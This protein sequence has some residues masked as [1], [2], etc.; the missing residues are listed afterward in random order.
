MD[1]PRNACLL[2]TSWNLYS[3]LG[4]QVDFV[5]LC[6]QVKEGKVIGQIR[7]GIDF[8]HKRLNNKYILEARQ[9]CEMMAATA[10]YSNE[11]KVLLGRLLIAENKDIEALDILKEVEEDGC[12]KP[13]VIEKI[14]H[15]RSGHL[16]PRPQRREL[17]AGRD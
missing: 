8:A 9:I 4:E 10:Q 13:F 6:K 17:D 12:I 14:H 7:G 16:L 15:S 3:T 11:Y 1:H 2:Y 5:D